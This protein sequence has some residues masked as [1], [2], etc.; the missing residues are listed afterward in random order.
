MF[1]G[2]DLMDVIPPSALPREGDGPTYA[3]DREILD[4]HC[5]DAEGAKEALQKPILMPAAQL[6]EK[7]VGILSV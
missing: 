7:K 4:S 5:S 3:I 6:V 2:L 1:K